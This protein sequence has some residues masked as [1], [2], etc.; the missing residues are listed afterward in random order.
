MLATQSEVSDGT[1]NIINVGIE[2]FNQADI[3]VA[4]NQADP[5]VLGVGYIWSG[6][7]SIQFLPTAGTPGGFVPDGVTVLLRRNT[8][9]DEMYNVYDGG[10]PFSRLTLDENFEQL[11]LLSQ[12]FSEGLGLDSLQQNLDMHNYRILNLGTPQTDTDAV[13]KG[14]MD[15]R[16]E[17]LVET[18][19]GPIASA[20]NVSYI[21]PASNL[22]NLQQLSATQGSAMIQHDIRTVSAK[23][24]EIVSVRDFPGCDPTGLTDSSA[25][26]TAAAAVGRQVYIPTGT[27]LL[28][29]ITIPSGTNFYGDGPN[30]SIVKPLVN[31][32]RGAITIN[33]SGPTATINFISFRNMRFVSDVQTS[34]FSEQVHLLTLNGVSGCLIDNCHFIGFRGDGLYIGSGDTGGQERH[35]FNITVQNCRFDGLNND[36]RNAISIIDGTN[37]T[38]Q[39][40]VFLNCTRNNM[41][42]A[43]DIEPD[44]FAFHVID[45]I[46]ILNNSFRNVGGNL[47]VVSL[48][49]SS[50]VVPSPRGIMVAGNNFGD[51]ITST[52]HA[53]IFMGT[54]R[55]LTDSDLWS[56]IRIVNNVGRNGCRAID[57]RAVKGVHIEDNTWQGYTKNSNFGIQS[58]NTQAPRE[59]YHGRNRYITNGYLGGPGM[60]VGAV[61]YLTHEKNTWEDCG[62][63]AAGSYAL[64]YLPGTSTYIKHYQNRFKSASGATLNGVVNS[65]AGWDIATNTQIGDEFLNLLSNGF[66]AHESDM[67]WT[68]Y[69][70][71]VEGATTPGSGTYTLQAGRFRR[72][73]KMVEFNVELRV[74]AGHTAVGQL[75]EVSLPLAAAS[76]GGQQYPMSVLACEGLTG[77][78]ATAYGLLN[79]L[80]AAGG[81]AGAVRLYANSATT[82]TQLLVPA[83]A[84][85]IWLK[86]EYMAA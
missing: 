57:I 78:T 17:D 28:N 59:V 23:I 43:I 34:G 74:N 11:L 7:T 15:D 4:L 30:R 1:L 36:N 60:Q 25:A 8:K 41:P 32:L 13:S 48:F 53:E 3:S 22:R 68:T 31:T 14:Y 85:I 46:N 81:V 71:I 86:G 2:F 6:A 42:G 84:F 44:N 47:G 27:Y 20:V 50:N 66:A 69:V 77:S 10:A 80:A 33:S 26:F 51:S 37:I 58:D 39:N 24:S 64:E 62:N 72:T 40:N 63:G 65:G 83:G 9:N 49:M 12:E 73:G 38:I 55:V 79:S 52:L 75:I 21:D 82:Q 16:I 35:N 5:L 18:G 54:T 61:N 29:A 56:G 67:A 76:L 45:G 19:Q 70:P